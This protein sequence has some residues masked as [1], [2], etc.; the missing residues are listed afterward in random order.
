MDKARVLLVDDEPDLREA[1]SEGLELAGHC[2][3]TFSGASGVIG[4][5]GRDF[6]GVLVT[7]IRMPDLSGM[8]L[9]R[10]TQEHYPDVEVIL[11][12][13]YASTESAIEALRLG[14][15]DYLAVK[16]A[17]MPVEEGKEADTLNEIARLTTTDPKLAYETDEAADDMDPEVS[18]FDLGKNPLGYAE[19]QITLAKELLE[20]AQTQELPEGTSY[21]ELTRAFNSGLSKIASGARLANRYVGGVHIRR[22]R[23]GTGNPIYQPVPAEKQRDAVKLITDTMFS[24]DSFKFKPEFV[25]RLAQERFD[26]WGDQNIHTGQS[27]LRV[28]SRAL[29]SLYDNDIAQR[30]IDN[31]E[32][33]AADAPVYKL[34][35]MY[36]TVQNKI[37][38]EVSENKEISQARR[39]LQRE[40][41]DVVAD[42]LAAG[43]EAPG[44]AK[45]MLSA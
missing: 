17:Y 4:H 18:R 21:K 16:Y 22:D 14:A 35:E 9:L 6:Y 30:L 7:D 10:H 29:Q 36:D 19:K 45:S 26:N 37:W 13:G 8:A 28:Q 15:Y 27:V 41:I 3:S 20:R 34:S 42:K 39:D 23:A 11:I 12:T 24:P 44:E 33:L 5:L 25:S 32:K 40:Y 43:S 31:P 1:L 2:V 38:S